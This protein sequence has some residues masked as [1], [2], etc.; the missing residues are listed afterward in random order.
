MEPRKGTQVCGFWSQE[1]EGEG[2]GEGRCPGSWPPGLTATV[3]PLHQ[4]WKSRAL[5]DE[6][7]QQ[8]DQNPDQR[9]QGG[10][11]WHAP[12]W[13]SRTGA[14]GWDSSQVRATGCGNRLEAEGQEMRDFQSQR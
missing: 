14:K 7:A 1:P 10:H 8:A 2:L 9:L 4:P 13:R 12:S 6:P 11:G 5:R 3:G